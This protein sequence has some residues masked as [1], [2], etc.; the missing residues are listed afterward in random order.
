MGN[1]KELW[2]EG[3]GIREVYTDD[4]VDDLHREIERLRNACLMYDRKIHEKDLVIYHY[5]AV[6]ERI[7]PMIQSEVEYQAANEDEPSLELPVALTALR[8]T[9][10]K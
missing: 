10:E 8:D 1:T 5:R 9:L 4:Y 6:L 2:L 3:G 7:L